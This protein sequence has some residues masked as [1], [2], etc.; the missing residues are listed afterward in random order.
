MNSTSKGELFRPV[1]S[2]VV[3][4]GLITLSLWVLRPFLPAVVWATMIAVSTWPLMLAVQKRLWGRR[5]LAVVVMS[6]ALLLVFVVP[7]SLAI[8]TIVSHAGDIKGWAAAVEDGVLGPPP[9][10]LADLPYVGDKLV[11]HWSQLTSEGALRGRLTPYVSEVLSWFVGQVGSL[12]AITMQFLLTI[13]IAAVL[14][15]KGELARSGIVAFA[16]RVSE[17]HGEDSVRLA[18][19]A[20]RGVA[21]GVVGTALVQSVLGG[22]GLA[23]SGVP[24]AAMLTAIMFLLAVA[25]IGPIPVL[26]CSV[27]WL[28][29]K[30]DTAW[31]TALLVWSIIVGTMDNFLRP[32]FI[33]K[34]ADLPLLLIFSG[35]VGGLIAFGLVGLF[36]G[37]MVLAVTWKLCVAWVQNAPDATHDDEPAQG[38]ASSTAAGTPSSTPRSSASS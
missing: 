23:V 13:V 26:A 16:R 21:M 24:L 5:T 32:Y 34:G 30:D 29:M 15:A 6:I 31:A 35:V 28:Y 11:A 33:R 36:I 22:I 38:V 37:P 3:L 12:G 1:I 2:I 7:L 17:E 10:W 20:I 9:H 14:Y 19:Q 8:G 25:Q 4:G 27:I 18:G